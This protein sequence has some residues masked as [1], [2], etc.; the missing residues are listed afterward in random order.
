MKISL[1]IIASV[2][3]LA[4]CSPEGNGFKTSGGRAQDAIRAAQRVCAKHEGV[5]STDMVEDAS[6][7]VIAVCMDGA[8]RYGDG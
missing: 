1:L 8:I 3:L 6:D 2:V 4:G 5:R 7:D